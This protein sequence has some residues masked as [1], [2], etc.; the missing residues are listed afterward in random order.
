MRTFFFVLLLALLSLAGRARAEDEDGAAVAEAAEAAEAEEEA[1][2]REGPI[3]V[4]FGVHLND[5]QSI[6]L[7]THNYALD[8]YVWFRWKGEEFDPSMVEVINPYELWGHIVTTN[9]EEPE[10]LPTGELY[11]VMRIQGLFS[12]K[13]P[14]YN[15]PF[16]RQR[17]V[18]ILEDSVLEARDLVF[19]P[20]A[21]EAS[22]VSAGVS[23]PGYAIGTPL[24][25]V[26]EHRYP[27]RFGD[28]R[29]EEPS[30]YSR[31]LFEIPITRPPVAYGAKVLLP[32][33][34]VV[35]CAALMFLLA[36][37]YVDSRVNL[38]ITSLLTVVALQMTY[39]QDLPD[40]GYL[41]LMDKIYIAT[42]LFVI[43]GLALVLR[44]TRMVEAG[45][46]A[47]ALR[48][49]RIGLGGLLGTYLLVTLAMV[50]SAYTDG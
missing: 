26:L 5:I 47:R 30:T 42:Y 10:E 8:V 23:L 11:Q 12:K 22:T 45:D 17:L 33:L 19:A 46:A 34:C 31:I 9:Y 36:P 40:V 41:M 1:P 48:V 21:A 18:M 24:L 29:S 32:V 28:T 49:N 37:T 27:T 15:Y 20:D 6:D 14:L 25:G 13:L 4:S 50:W 16:D 3:R 43:A 38:G 39:N 44:A 7:K 2:K 35:V